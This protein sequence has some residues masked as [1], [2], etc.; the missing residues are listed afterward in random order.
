MITAATH[1]AKLNSVLASLMRGQGWRELFAARLF[2]HGLQYVPQGKWLKFMLWHVREEA[3][4]YAGV[5]EVYAQ[6]TGEALHPWVESKL[7]EKAL[8]LTGSWLE[9]A[10]AQF[11]YDRGGYW[12]L[13]EYKN[14]PFSPYRQLAGRI[15]QEEEGHQQV[16][17]D[18]LVALCADS[19]CRQKAQQ[20][21]PAWLRLGLQSFGRPEESTEAYALSA[22]LKAR[23]TERVMQDFLDD[24]KPAMRQ[25][26]LTFPAA[27][28]LGLSLPSRLDWQL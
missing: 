28:S 20:L 16:G 18:I 21:F 15:L 14:C 27:D 7:A 22:G 26:G 11:L 3:Q 2:G 19:E 1:D 17:E 5:A 12:Q 10:L 6:L 13:R 8:P 25:C 23:P 4:H 24:I 9:L